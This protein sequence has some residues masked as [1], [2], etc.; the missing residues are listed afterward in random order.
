MDD[1]NRKD[2]QF[3]KKILIFTDPGFNQIPH[4]KINAYVIGQEQVIP[5]D[6]MTRYDEVNSMKILWKTM[7]L[8]PKIQID[9]RPTIQ[10]KELL[11]E[12]LLLWK[13]YNDG[14]EKWINLFLLFGNVKLGFN[15]KNLNKTT[16]L[17]IPSASIFGENNSGT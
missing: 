9:A 8:P 4:L 16:N 12:F 2:V 3:Q 17:N 14:H 11:T 15:R 7:K 1:Y 13:N 6:D 10:R 5:L